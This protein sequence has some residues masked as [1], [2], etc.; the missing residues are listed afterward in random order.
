MMNVNHNCFLSQ[1]TASVF[2][3]ILSLQVNI[4]IE[5]H[6]LQQSECLEMAPFCTCTYYDLKNTKMSIDCDN[7]DYFVELN[8]T[9]L[10]NRIFYDVKLSPKQTNILMQQTLNLKS[11]IIDSSATVYLNNIDAFDI[12]SNP[13]EHANPSSLI[14]EL[15][16]DKSN[17]LNMFNKSKC[18]KNAIYE[19]TLFSSFKV[20]KMMPSSYNAIDICPF[21]F[22]NSNLELLS[23]ELMS[24]DIPVDSKIEFE[25]LST[26][27]GRL[28][29]SNISSF[30]IFVNYRLVT[31]DRK[32]LEPFTFKRIQTFK[33]FNTIFEMIDDGI[34]SNFNHLT[35]LWLG[36]AN[37]K[38]FFGKPNNATWL[39]SLS[40]PIDQQLLVTL[41]DETKK[42][43][44][45]YLFPESDF[46]KFTDFTYD[47]NVFVQI[48]TDKDKSSDFHYECTCTLLWLLQNFQSYNNPY[49]DKYVSNCL[50][51]NFNESIDKC[52][53]EKRLCVCDGSCLTTTTTAT[54]TSTTIAN[55]T[56]QIGL[57]IIL[58]S[59]VIPS[60]GLILVIVGFIT[61]FYRRKRKLFRKNIVLYKIMLVI[62]VIVNT[63][64][65]KTL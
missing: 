2:I 26:D 45:K 37:M 39:G 52:Q 31:L 50:G 9:L 55:N 5:Q 27:E 29:N 25:Q 18:D 13:F 47:K 10:K 30:Y 17:I 48:L 64:F 28:L 6:A 15:D 23:L 21:F 44:D 24:L 7:F 32:I 54:I 34:F 1:I 56:T 4:G 38:E 41:E 12:K 57:T 46:C 43:E 60:T 20:I 40:G 63:I 16:I 49:N 51:S 61:Y 62:K 8:F 19:R 65:L 11:I 3:T 36:I 33:L 59:T 53:F 14:N 42:N 35:V 22:H 58:L